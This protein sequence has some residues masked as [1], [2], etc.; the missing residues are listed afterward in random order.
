[1]LDAQVDAVDHGG[2]PVVALDY[3]LQ[4]DGSHRFSYSFNR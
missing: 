1:V 4:V 2:L 3:A